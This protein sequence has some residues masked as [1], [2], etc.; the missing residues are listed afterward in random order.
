MSSGVVSVRMEK[1]MEVKLAIKNAVDVVRFKLI[2]LLAGKKGVAINIIISD[3]KVN[4]KNNQS[5]FFHNLTVDLP[6][7]TATLSARMDWSKK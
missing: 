5:Y 2:K 1:V 3:G 7:K 6:S 4:I